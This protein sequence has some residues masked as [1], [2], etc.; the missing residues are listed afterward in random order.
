MQVSPA[1]AQRRQ[2]WRFDTAGPVF[3]SPSVRSGT[4]FA[5]AIAGLR[6]GGSLLYRSRDS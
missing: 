4:V 1:A 3:S 5:G 6:S 2:L